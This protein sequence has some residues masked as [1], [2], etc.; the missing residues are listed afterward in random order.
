MESQAQGD[1]GRTAGRGYHHGDL[2]AALLTAAAALL[3]E[4]GAEALSLRGLARRTGVSQTAP[5]NHF[6]SKDDLLARLA[7]DGFRRLAAA[8]ATVLADAAADGALIA[9]GVDYV[10]FAVRAPQLYRLMFGAGLGGSCDDAGVAAAKHASFAPLKQA[11]RTGEAH[12]R[13]SDAEHEAAAVAAWSLVHGLALLVIDGS[14]RD[15][16]LDGAVPSLTRRVL[17]RFVAGVG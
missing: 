7:E 5:Y 2:R 6:A 8:Q 13:W 16:G 10:R 4:Q 17:D 3:E 14:L 1:G 12:A 11:L 15:P 9:L